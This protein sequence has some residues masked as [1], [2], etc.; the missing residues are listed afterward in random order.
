VKDKQPPG[1]SYSEAQ[2]RLENLRKG[3]LVK[4]KQDP[5]KSLHFCSNLLVGTEIFLF[6]LSPFFGF[7]LLVFGFWFWA[8]GLR[9]LIFGFGAQRSGHSDSWYEI[10]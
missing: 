8:F 5:S 7:W 4:E 2:R 10:Y 3:H 9:L 6:I 1:T